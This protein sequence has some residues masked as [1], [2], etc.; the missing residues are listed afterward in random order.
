MEKCFFSN[1]PLRWSPLITFIGASD[2]EYA[3]R[4]RTTPVINQKTH[5]PQPKPLKCKKKD[6]TWETAIPALSQ[7]MHLF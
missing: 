4:M 3:I 1:S 2:S 6:A 7:I 5:R